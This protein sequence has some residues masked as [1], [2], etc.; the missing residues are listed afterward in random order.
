MHSRSMCK[1]VKKRTLLT[2]DSVNA[3]HVCM[4]TDFVEIVENT[5]KFL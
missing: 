5:L 3:T 1:R 4:Y 2:K